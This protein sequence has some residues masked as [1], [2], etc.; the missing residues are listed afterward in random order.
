MRLRAMRGEFLS[1]LN[2]FA[3]ASRLYAHILKRWKLCI[4]QKSEEMEE[5]VF[6]ITHIEFTAVWK[7]VKQYRTGSLCI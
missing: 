2:E 7:V 4:T 3:A 6:P 1:S 5:K